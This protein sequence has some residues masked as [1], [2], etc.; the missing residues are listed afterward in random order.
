[1]P[2]TQ[3]SL[4]SGSDSSNVSSYT[5]ASVTP[6]NGRLMLVAVLN[7]KGST[8]DTPTLS[9]NG[10]TWTQQA[11]ITFNTIASPLS[12]ATLF[13]GVGTG[14]AGAIT[15]DF[16]GVNQ[17]GCAWS[18]NEFGDVDTATNNGV[19]Q[20][21]TNTADS[22]TALTVTLAAFGSTNNATYRTKSRQRF[23]L[24]AFCTPLYRGQPESICK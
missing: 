21:A 3:G 17:T 1:M 4:T 13:R 19:V 14:T 15:I 10:M 23:T 24:T 6:T 22:V 20:S 9:G 11:T 16:G 5:T 7:T 12:G 8:P 18:V 2:V